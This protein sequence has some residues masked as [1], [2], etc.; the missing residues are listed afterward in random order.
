M[1]ELKEDNKRDIGKI[2]NYYGG[3]SVISEGGKFYW[4]IENWDG[5]FWEEIPQYLFV[6]INS[7]Q[8]KLDKGE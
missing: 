1:S 8:D 5:T 6:A 2:G 3:L 4:G 7:H